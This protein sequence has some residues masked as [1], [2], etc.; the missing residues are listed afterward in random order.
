MSSQSK[1]TLSGFDCSAAEGVVLDNQPD[2]VSLAYPPGYSIITIQYS[3]IKLISKQDNSVYY[4]SQER[5]L[6]CGYIITIQSQRATEHRRRHL[7]IIL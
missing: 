4:Q 3:N 1:S 2:S 6:S 5:D 7:I